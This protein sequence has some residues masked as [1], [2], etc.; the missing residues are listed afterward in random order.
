M[1]H[2]QPSQDDDESACRWQRS[3]KRY[4]RLC[5]V[6][7]HDL[8]GFDVR[9]E[10][11]MVISHTPGGCHTIQVVLPEHTGTSRATYEVVSLLNKHREGRDPRIVRER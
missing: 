4:T 6:I 11:A 2:D 1:H 7:T 5:I 9:S 3:Q 8:V 10:S